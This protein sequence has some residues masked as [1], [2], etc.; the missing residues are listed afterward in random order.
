MKP[1]PIIELDEIKA[2][3]PYSAGAHGTYYRWDDKT[4]LKIMFDLDAKHEAEWLVILNR[5]FP[6]L[7]PQFVKLVTVVIG[8]KVQQGYLMEHINGITVS[9]IADSMGWSPTQEL[10]FVRPV[11]KKLASLG[12][13]WT[14]CGG[15]NIIYTYDLKLRAVDPDPNYFRIV[16]KNL[17]DK[18]KKSDIL[19]IEKLIRTDKGASNGQK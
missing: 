9:E 11:Y 5:L 16:T 8:G 7:F 15:Q 14:D 12:F 18:L 6:G 1:S 10:A 2:D 17:L 13:S 19:S 3:S 4:G